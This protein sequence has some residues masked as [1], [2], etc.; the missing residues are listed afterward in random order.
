VTVTAH[1]GEWG[2]IMLYMYDPRFAPLEWIVRKRLAE[3]SY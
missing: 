1:G 2:L 3:L